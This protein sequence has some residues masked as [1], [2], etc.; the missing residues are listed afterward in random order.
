ME[1]SD[2]LDG[3]DRAV[4]EYDPEA[5]AHWARQAVA[6]KLDPITALAVLT[7]A[8]REVGDGFG[9]GELWL[10][11]L[12]AAAEAMSAATVVLE[13]EVAQ[14]GLQRV[15][16]GVVVIGTVFGDIH[17]IGKNMVA[18]LLSAAGFTVHDLGI[19]VRA[20]TFV[21]AVIKHKAQVLALS[22]LLTT[23]APEQKRVIDLLTAADI[24]QQVK[25]IV[26]GGGITAEFATAIG[27]DGYDPTAPGA[28]KLAKTLLAL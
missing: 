12:I 3:L 20:E 22:A 28:V 15:G 19:N 8:I 18:T 4:I 21:E 6:Q 27:A 10:P 24:R 17:D 16:L 14:Q 5:A 26:G 2:I 9:S 1:A 11:D 13:A 25:V 7:D 23:T